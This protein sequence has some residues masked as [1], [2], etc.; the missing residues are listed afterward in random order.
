MILSILKHTYLNTAIF[1]YPDDPC[2]FNNDTPALRTE[3]TVA[4]F[5]VEIE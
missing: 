5:K 3:D 4:V 1:T 2:G